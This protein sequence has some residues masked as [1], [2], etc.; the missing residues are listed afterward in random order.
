[1]STRRRRPGVILPAV[2]ALIGLLSVIMAGFVFFLR[3]ETEGILAYAEGQQARLAAESGLE[4]V[5]ALLRQERDN[6]LAWYDVPDRFRHALVWAEQYERDSDPLRELGSRRE[7]LAREEALTPAW[8]FSVVAPRLDGPPDTMR[9]GLMPESAKLNLNAASE[10]QIRKLLTPLLLNLGIEN[11]EEL[12]AAILDWRDEDDETRDGGAENDYYNSLD[13]G[14]PYNAKNGRFDSVEELLLVKGITAAVLYGED[15]NRNGI[16][17]ANED[18]GEESFPYYDNGDGILDLGIAPFLTVWS[19][20]LDVSSDNRQRLNLHKNRAELEAQLAAYLLT[21][22]EAEEE[23]QGAVLSPAS[24]E[25]IL[26]LAGN[27]A[28]VSRLRSP[29]DLYV[30]EEGLSGGEPNDPNAAV[31]LPSELAASPITLEELPVVMDY[32]STRPLEQAGQPIEGLINI[33]VAPFNVLMVI[34]HMT[35]EAAAAIVSARSELDAETLRSPAWPLTTGTLDAA[36]FKAIAPYI[37]T[38]AYQFHVEV[39]GYGDHVKVTRRLEWVIEMIGPLAQIKYHR[40]LTR[41]GPA[42]PIDEENV[43]VIPG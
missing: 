15:V 12:I 14:P 39:L 16:L 2:L 8:R 37:T 34:P 32:F 41:L 38:R 30:G 28:V 7:L 18:D 5:V 1:M 19:R 21:G 23:D 24:L 6:V 20:E 4:E 11:P 31:E 13:P 10:E 26:S 27:E 29:A 22:A 3:A 35:A 9:F 42:W 25:F 40:D 33:N 43:I 17:D 36:V